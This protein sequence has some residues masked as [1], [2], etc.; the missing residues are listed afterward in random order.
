MRRLAFFLSFLAFFAPMP[1]MA[2]GQSLAF[3]E[4]V[5]MANC[6]ACHGEDATTGAPGDIRGLPYGTFVR[7]LRGI[8]EMP[9]FTFLL[10]EEVE[11]LA[12]WL[13][14]PAPTE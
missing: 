8:E 10:P 4:E 11:A 9:S 3:G 6:A 1:V 14:I 13:R 2:E 7:A 5:Y 12:A